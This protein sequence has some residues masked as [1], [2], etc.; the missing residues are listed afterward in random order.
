MANIESYKHKAA[1]AV[2]VGWLRDA[3]AQVGFDGHASIAGL[4]WRVNRYGPGF[5]VWSEY[6]IAVDPDGRRVGDTVV[7]D[8]TSWWADPRLPFCGPCQCEP[9]IL[10]SC[11]GPGRPPTYDE[12]LAMRYRPLVIFD[13]A[14]QHKGAL[15]YAVEIVHRSPPSNEK[16]ELLSA[17]ACETFVLDAEWVLRQV[18]PPARLVALEVF[19]SGPWRAFDRQR[20]RVA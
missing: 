8:E 12:L 9:F 5:G 17:L 19:G 1:K 4:S 6:P 20:R 15:R 10:C 13:L 14:V 2:V 16:R 7:W 3:A 18:G 11:G